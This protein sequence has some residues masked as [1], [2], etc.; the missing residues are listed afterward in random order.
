MKPLNGTKT[1]PKLQSR[2]A[3][4]LRKTETAAKQSA[5]RNTAKQAAR[6]NGA[7]QRKRTAKRQ[8]PPSRQIVLGLLLAARASPARES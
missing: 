4:K 7:A 1:A 5:Q 3:P 8:K 6:H 2:T